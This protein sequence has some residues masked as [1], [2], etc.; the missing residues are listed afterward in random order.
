MGDHRALITIK[1]EAHGVKRE[2]K[3]WWIN[4]CP[5]DGGNS[6][7]QRVREFFEE[8]WGDARDAWDRAESKRLRD[9]RKGREVCGECGR[10]QAVE[11]QEDKP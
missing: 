6:L 11:M 8:W 5:E 9:E 10:A 3:E 1:V 7:D 4:Y 2:A